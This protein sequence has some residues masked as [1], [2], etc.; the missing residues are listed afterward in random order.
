M[1]GILKNITLGNLITK[2][3]TFILKFITDALGI[4][5]YNIWE[6]VFGL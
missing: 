4:K 2:S 1:C 5:I 3:N 6:N